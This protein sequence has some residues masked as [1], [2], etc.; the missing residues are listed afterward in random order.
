MDL[1]LTGGSA[2]LGCTYT[3]DSLALLLRRKEKAVYE[4]EKADHEEVIKALETATAALSGQYLST[5]IM[6]DLIRKK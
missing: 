6:V 2:N 5:C 1:P 4:K 3:L